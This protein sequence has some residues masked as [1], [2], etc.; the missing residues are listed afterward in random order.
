MT[1]GTRNL[2]ASGVVRAREASAADRPVWD[3]FVEEASAGD[4]LQAWGWG[5]VA[6]GWGEAPRRFL[7]QDEDGAIR[8][9]AQVLVR[10][11]PFGRSVLYVPHGPLWL[12]RQP[13]GADALRELLAAV[14]AAGQAARG[15]VVKLDPRAE[16]DVDPA[17]LANDLAGL[18]CRPARHDLQARATRV[19]D[20]SLG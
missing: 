4:P 2:P 19:L 14:R 15:I 1:A 5:N 20:L 11:A 7:A 18:G 9:V 12:R 13:A 3:R 16:A 17:G 8:G 6:A 10:A